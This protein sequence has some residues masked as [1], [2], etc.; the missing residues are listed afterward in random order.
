MLFGDLRQ[1]RNNAFRSGYPVFWLT[2]SF[3]VCLDGN[4]RNVL[5]NFRRFVQGPVHVCDS[6]ANSA[7]VGTRADFVDVG[8]GKSRSVLQALS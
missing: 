8:R 1:R 7:N 3:C 2:G 6:L 5:Q 4:G